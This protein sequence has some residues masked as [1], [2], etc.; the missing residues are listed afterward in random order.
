METQRRHLGIP[1]EPL[2]ARRLLEARRAGFGA[3]FYLRANA[4]RYALLL[5]VGL[6]AAALLIYMRINLALVFVLGLLL[7]GFLRDLGW[8][9]VI[10]LT[11][12]FTEKVTNWALVK[13]LAS[14]SDK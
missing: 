1:S 7:G 11:A 4:R 14:G 13:E 2:L 8:F 10:R 5:A 3:G 12:P 6:L 9:R